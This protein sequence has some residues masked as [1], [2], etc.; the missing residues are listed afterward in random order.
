MSRP[1]RSKLAPDLEAALAATAADDD[2][3]VSASAEAPSWEGFHVD[4][5]QALE[6]Q[7]EARVSLGESSVFFVRQVKV[8]SMSGGA[9]RCIF[10]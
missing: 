8:D 4:L 1:R 5:M 3:R 10:L 7:F 9:V 2:G 6:K